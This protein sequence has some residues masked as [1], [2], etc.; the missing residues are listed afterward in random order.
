MSTKQ[1]SQSGVWVTLEGFWNST[2]T[3]FFVGPFG[4]KIRVRLGGNRIGITRQEQT[5]DNVTTKRLEVGKS[6]IV[7]ARM[8]VMVLEPTTISFDIIPGTVANLPPAS[9]F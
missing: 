7:Y 1:I 4:A 3:G 8:Q 2:A 5:L 6:S 9:E